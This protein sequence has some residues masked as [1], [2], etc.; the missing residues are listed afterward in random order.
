[1][2]DPVASREA[3]LR[4]DAVGRSR[5]GRNPRADPAATV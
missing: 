5:P 2:D 4:G 1:V 3:G